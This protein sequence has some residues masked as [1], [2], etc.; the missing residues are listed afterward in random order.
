MNRNECPKCRESNAD[1]VHTV[2]EPD[3]IIEVHVCMEC[4]LEYEARF[5]LFERTV[6]G[7]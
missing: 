2:R 1:H 3:T 7:Q 5:N 4:G 6:S